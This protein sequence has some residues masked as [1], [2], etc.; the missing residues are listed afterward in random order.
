MGPLARGREDDSDEAPARK[1]GA[2]WRRGGDAGDGAADGAAAGAAA[3]AQEGGQPPEEES[4]ATDPDRLLRL[5][6]VFAFVSLLVGA[7]AL[8]LVFAIAA[9][10]ASGKVDLPVAAGAVL[11]SVGSGLLVARAVL[12]AL[13]AR[14]PESDELRSLTGFVS[15]GTGFVLLGAVAVFLFLTVSVTLSGYGEAAF[16]V[17]PLLVLA[18]FT[19]QFMRE[20]TDDF[21]KRTRLRRE[22]AL[23]LTSIAYFALTVLIAQL[24]FAASVYAPIALVSPADGAVVAAGTPLDIEVNSPGAAQVTYNRGSGALPLPAPYD[25]NTSA[26]ADGDYAVAVTASSSDGSSATLTFHVTID[27][28]PPAVTITSPPN[29]TQQLVTPILVSV[30][31]PHLASVVW[32]EANLTPEGGVPLAAPYTIETSSWPYGQFDVTVTATDAA[33]NSA[34]ATLHV[35]KSSR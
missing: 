32:S 23:F 10:V 7:F 13:M 21:L 20:A 11:V 18:Y 14:R 15:L 28:S 25:V 22:T 24:L 27:S 4:E 19:L 35:E 17:L 6:F 26:W 1:R 2:R 33:G 30:N 16:F 8:L 5:R 34:V 29:N 9:I 31:D 12:R 3:G